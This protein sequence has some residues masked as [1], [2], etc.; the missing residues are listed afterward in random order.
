[1]IDANIWDKDYQEL[2]K[3]LYDSCEVCLKFQKTPARPIVSLPLATQ[4]NETVAMDL[5]VWNNNKLNILYLIDMFTRFTTARIIKDKKPETIIDNVMQ[6][7]IGNGFGAPAKFLA[8]N[9]GE[10]ANEEY[11]AYPS[12]LG[13]S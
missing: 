13:W 6:M 12:N 10:F 7:W 4:F 8:D 11:P 1:M 5:K 3:K 9:G 2:A